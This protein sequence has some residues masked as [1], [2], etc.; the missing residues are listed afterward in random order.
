MAAMVLI[1]EPVYAL[2]ITPTAS[3]CSTEEEFVVDVDVPGFYVDEL[4]VEVVDR[5]L[6]VQGKATPREGLLRPEFEF[7]FALP[8]LADDSAVEAAFQDGVLTVRAPLRPREG[9]R[10]IEIATTF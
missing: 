7:W 3:V 1:D 10:P 8:G 9:S 2:D 6:H 5:A 4:A